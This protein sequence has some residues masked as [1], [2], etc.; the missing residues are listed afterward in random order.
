VAV[1]G[2]EA[3]VQWQAVAGTFPW[4][5]QLEALTPVTSGRTDRP[6]VGFQAGKDDAGLLFS[7]YLQAPADGKYTFS[8]KTDG[9][10]LLRVH[11]AT[12]I[13]ADFGYKAGEEKSES[14]LLTAGKHPIRLYFVKRAAADKPSL[15]LQWSGPGIDKQPVPASAFWIGG[16]VKN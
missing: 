9:G 11:E 4:V 5:P 15:D 12:V 7:G 1:A 6:D 10:A 14:I 8:L 3:G 13:D 2:A 16:N